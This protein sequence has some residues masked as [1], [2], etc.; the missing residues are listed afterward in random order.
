MPS[1]ESNGHR[2]IRS[3]QW[4]YENM[5]TEQRRCRRRRLHD[6]PDMEPG[7]DVLPAGVRITGLGRGKYIITKD[8]GRGCGLVRVE[9]TVWTRRHFV[10]IRKPSYVRPEDWMIVPRGLLDSR[11][12]RQMAMDAC[13]DLVVRYAEPVADSA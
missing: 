6:F 12:I 8:C 2:T 9:Y 5:P 4:Y 11:K 13:H 7:D 10:Q 1:G 3:A